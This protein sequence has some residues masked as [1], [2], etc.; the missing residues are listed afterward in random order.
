MHA[1]WPR[2]LQEQR[3]EVAAEIRRDSRWQAFEPERAA[4]EWLRQGMLVEGCSD[5]GSALR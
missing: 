5:A 4:V 1:Q 2:V 3:D